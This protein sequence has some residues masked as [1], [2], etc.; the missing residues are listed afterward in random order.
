M[1]EHESPEPRLRR[2]QTDEILYDFSYEVGRQIE[3]G[4]PIVVLKMTNPKGDVLRF[5]FTPTGAETLGSAL[6]GASGPVSDSD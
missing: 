3:S 2:R 6:S 5:G 4:Q 1:S